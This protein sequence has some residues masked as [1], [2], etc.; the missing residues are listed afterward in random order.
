MPLEVGDQHIDG[1]EFALSPGGS[2]L[3][4]KVAIPGYQPTPEKSLT[5]TLERLDFQT[6]ASPN[7]KVAEDGTFTLKNVFTGKYRVRLTGLP[8][9][10]YVKIVKSGSQEVDQDGADL[11]GGSGSLEIQVSQTGA[12]VE[13]TIIGADGKPLSGATAVLIPASG[14]ESHYRSVTAEADGSFNIKGVVPGKYQLLAWEDLEQGAYLDP[15]FVKP[16]EPSAQDLV[17]EDSVK[18]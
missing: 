16:Y 18:L 4:G 9:N 11:S 15:D 17:L 3:S 14:R 7:A 2:E 8:D 6:G 5:V 12:Q 10:A 13:G 1:L